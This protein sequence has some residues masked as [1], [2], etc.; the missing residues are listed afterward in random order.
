MKP[1]SISRLGK[2]DEK[3]KTRRIKLVMGSTD[4][5]S[6]IMLRLANLKNAE[7]KFRATSVRDDHSLEERKF[8]KEWVQIAEAQNKAGNTDE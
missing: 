3:N 1:Q 4:E 7:E 8:I 2:A 6:Q 5:K